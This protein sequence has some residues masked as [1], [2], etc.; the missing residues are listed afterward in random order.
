[1][2]VW[3]NGTVAGTAGRISALD[4]GLLVGDGVFETLR[5][6]DGM[7]FAWRR[8][9]ERLCHS[10]EGLGLT[11]PPSGE[12]RAAADA[13]L[14]AEGL[15]APGTGARLRITVTGGEAPLGSER[16]AAPPT[17]VVAASP[18]G[19]HDPTAAVVTVPWARNER[20]AVAGLKTISYA[21][22]V[23]A[24]AYARER[25][26]GEAVFANTRGELCEATG[27]NV[28]V[29]LGGVLR[30]PPADSGCL[31]GV[32]RALTL[33]LAGDAGIPF[34]EANLPLD[35][36]HRADEAFL[37]STTREV[38]AIAAVDGTALPVAPGA[39]TGRLASA[40]RD[41]VRRDLDP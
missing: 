40:L 32:T 6:Y 10:A 17:V 20:G 27:S 29:V 24:L 18:L 30:T 11:V 36:L 21:E 7:P 4:H 3:V 38:Q 16:A 28:F 25:G 19:P 23:R 35:A 14:A 5:V 22:N 8:H 39:V 15:A 33:E 37:S 41:L 34:E 9:H 12:L 1:M 13:V 26:A 2:Q 31:L